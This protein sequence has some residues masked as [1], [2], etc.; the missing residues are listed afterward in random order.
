MTARK[1][2]GISTGVS[3]LLGLV[4]GAVMFFFE[5]TPDWL[6]IVFQSVGAVLSVLGFT[7][8]YPD[9]EKEK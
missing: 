2:K 4:A 1:T 5:A 6:P 8:V 9:K 7:I 3:G